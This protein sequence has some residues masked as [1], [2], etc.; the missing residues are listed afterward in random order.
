MKFL[1]V[2]QC[3]AAKELYSNH[4]TYHEGDS[5]LDLF[6]VEDGIIPARSNCRVDLGVSCQLKSESGGNF[7]DTPQYFSYNVYARSSIAKT[8]LILANG[9]GLIDA[10][11]LGNLKAAFY[12]TSDSDYPIK[13]GERYVQLARADLGE[14]SFQLIDSFGDR[15]SSRGTN[16]LGSTSK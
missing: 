5:G 8:P 13:K 3:E 14:I 4:S 9:V 7:D 12:N 15:T 16:G 11:Y 2:P 1:I 6:I 10:G